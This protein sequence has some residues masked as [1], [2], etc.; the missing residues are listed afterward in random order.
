MRQPSKVD[1]LRCASYAA[2]S[3]FALW[4]TVRGSCGGGVGCLGELLILLPALGLTVT[5]A[6]GAQLAAYRLDV[7]PRKQAHLIGFVIFLALIWI[8]T[9]ALT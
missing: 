1:V 3:F 8:F 5:F 7:G 9:S 6:L 2:I 4:A